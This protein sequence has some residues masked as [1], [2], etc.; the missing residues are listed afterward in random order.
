MESCLFLDAEP[1]PQFLINFRVAAVI[2]NATPAGSGGRGFGLACQL[3]EE[4]GQSLLACAK[5]RW[6]AKRFENAA[7]N[8]TCR[9]AGNRGTMY[10][11]TL[12]VTRAV[13]G[14]LGQGY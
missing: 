11:A 14:S 1:S 12:A 13:M 4:A 9:P 3:L 8:A 5:S 2:G 10:L 7:P 6:C